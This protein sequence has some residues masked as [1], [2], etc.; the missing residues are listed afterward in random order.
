[1]VHWKI[2]MSYLFLPVQHQ[3]R[4]HVSRDVGC[5]EALTIDGKAEIVV[6]D[7]ASYQ[8]LLDLIE[9]GECIERG[10]SEGCG[11]SCNVV[12]GQLQKKD[13]YAIVE[14]S[15]ASSIMNALV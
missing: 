11:S 9:R 13:S 4:Y 6:Q 5:S 10:D 12:K 15:I 2:F 7:A 1:M 3:R 14:E 8:R